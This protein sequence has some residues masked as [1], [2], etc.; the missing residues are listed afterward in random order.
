MGRSIAGKPSIAETRRNKRLRKARLLREARRKEREQIPLATDCIPVTT[1]ETKFGAFET[2]D[3]YYFEYFRRIQMEEDLTNNNIQV[4]EELE[5][6]ID[7]DENEGTG[8]DFDMALDIAHQFLMGEEWQSDIINFITEQCSDTNFQP[9]DISEGKFNHENYDTWCKFREMSE[10]K[11]TD[12]LES[13]GL[14]ADTLV[15]RCRRVLR[16][17]GSGRRKHASEVVRALLVIDDFGAFCRLVLDCQDIKL[18]ERDQINQRKTIPC[19]SVAGQQ[20]G[21]SSVATTTQARC[22]DAERKQLLDLPIDWIQQVNVARAITS[23]KDLDNDETESLIPWAQAALQLNENINASV[24]SPEDLLSLRSRV[25]FTRIDVDVFVAKKLLHGST[26][27]INN[28]EKSNQDENHLMNCLQRQNELQNEVT[29]Q[30]NVVLTSNKNLNINENMFGEMY[31]YMQ[32]ALTSSS[33]RSNRVSDDGRDV[34]PQR[35]GELVPQILKLLVLEAE[36]EYIVNEI[37]S[38]FEDEALSV[39]KVQIFDKS[40]V[41]GDGGS[42]AFESKEEQNEEKEVH[43]DHCFLDSI[44]Y[45][46]GKVLVG[47]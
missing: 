35:C 10:K 37:R 38:F 20:T 21:N 11:V 18:N 31:M 2:E 32:D 23:K 26:T 43:D 8:D 27:K 42:N 29:L 39:P 19:A 33:S 1:G 5:E 44:K 46:K 36:Q 30:R 22:T 9:N 7:S 34:I 6:E 14:Q 3:D 12:L 15:R 25:F 24:L 28:E 4:A 17:K 16:T 13:L 47:S 45:I 41:V 40:V